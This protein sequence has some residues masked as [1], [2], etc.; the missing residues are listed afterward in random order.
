MPS[1]RLAKNIGFC[2]GVRRAIGIVE[3]TLAKNDS[4]IYSLGPVIHNPRVIKQL[5]EKGLQIAKSLESVKDSSVLIL[6]SHG[7]P[8]QVFVA[9]NKRKIKLV[10][11]ICP[12]VSLVHSICDKL[13]RQRLVLI[14]IGDKKHPEIKSL[15]DLAPGAHIIETVKD[16][17]YNAFSNKKIGI[18]SQTTQS[19]DMFFRIV[20]EILKKNPQI[21][22]AHIYNTICLDTA[23]RQ[24]EAKDLAGSTDVFLVI[25]SRLSANTRR[26]LGIGRR[27]N[28]QTYLIES[29]ESGLPLKLSDA[30]TIG[31]ISGASTPQWLVEKIVKKINNNMEVLKRCQ[32]KI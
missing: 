32:S 20:G 2:S 25:G 30:H 28:P 21:L 23:R 8:R 12:Y 10:N 7:S 6:P 11:V 9:A 18:I 26:L 5:E 4:G 1:I 16:V 24:D 31:I 13:N 15:M 22:E 27:I 17:G 3:K 29:E 19:K 14:I